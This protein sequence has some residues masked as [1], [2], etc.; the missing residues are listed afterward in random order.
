MTSSD[1]RTSAESVYSRPP[2]RE[3]THGVAPTPPNPGVRGLGHHT[4]VLEADSRWKT[5]TL[6]YRPSHNDLG[7]PSKKHSPVHCVVGTDWI[8]MLN[9]PTCSGT[10]A[11]SFPSAASKVAATAVVV[12]V[13]PPTVANVERAEIVPSQ[14]LLE[15]HPASFQS[16][17][18]YVRCIGVVA[19]A[20]TDSIEM[21]SGGPVNAHHR[22]AH[23]SM[24][25]VTSY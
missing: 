7:D 17:A 13:L 14:F 11:P 5:N 19:A 23:V 4:S 12:V 22:R 9:S 25:R 16:N 18:K 20:S 3:I 24:R 1:E 8:E 2:Y 21:S 6:I 15:V 10:A